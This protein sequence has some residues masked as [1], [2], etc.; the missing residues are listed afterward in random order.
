MN[1]KANRNFITEIPVALPVTMPG[2]KKYKNRDRSR[3][4]FVFFKLLSVFFEIFKYAF[5]A[6]LP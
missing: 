6:T 1:G 3:F 2:L 4:Q 5:P